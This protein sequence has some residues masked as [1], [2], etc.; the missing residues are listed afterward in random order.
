MSIDL[1]SEIG[2]ELN[3]YL[4]I[5]N[6]TPVNTK[7]N[8]QIDSKDAKSTSLIK[9]DETNF[10][11]QS[12]ETIKIC[13]TV[14]NTMWGLYNHS[15]EVS[16]DGLNYIHRIPILINVYGSPVKIFSSKVVE[17]NDGEISLIR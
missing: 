12:Y 10:N 5:K 16:I 13:L 1:N 7:I 4:Y 17:N 2:K 8:V 9:L 11:L 6:T 3:K 15:I 14:L